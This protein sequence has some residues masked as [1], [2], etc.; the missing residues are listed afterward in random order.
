EASDTRTEAIAQTTSGTA[1]QR[2]GSARNPFA[3]L[4]GTAT[5]LVA[6][7]PST[8]KSGPS[9]ASTST[10]AGSGSSSSSGS[11]T[12]PQSGSSK[13]ESV[14]PAPSQPKKKIVIRYA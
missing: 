10:S 12:S 11:G 2:G 3:P 6:S 14:A 5:A 8:P 7:A 4:P 13:G 9:S 1:Y